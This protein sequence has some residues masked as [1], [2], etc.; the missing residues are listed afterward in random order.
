[1]K[2]KKFVPDFEDIPSPRHTTQQSPATEREDPFAEVDLGFVQEVAVAEARRCLACRRCIGC[3]L[4]L[5][6][7]DR[8]AIVYDEIPETVTLDI[9]AVILAPGGSEFDA[10]RARGLGYS[11]SLDVVSSMEFERIL[12]FSGPFGGLP[13]RPF[14][15][16][17]P[18]RIGFIQCVGSR[19]IYAGAPFCSTVC[20]QAMIRQVR[21][22][23]AKISSAE[24]VV[25]HRDIRPLGR[26]GERSLALLESDPRVRF[27]PVDSVEVCE[28]GASGH[29]D[30]RYK[31]RER[32][33]TDRFDLVVL[34]T[35][36]RGPRGAAELARR[37][38]IKV[39]RQGFAVRDGDAS[40]CSS[41]EGVFA[42]G[43]FAGPMGIGI[44]VSEG[45]GGA[46]AAA[47]AA[48]LT[49][50]GIEA[51]GPVDGGERSVESE[52]APAGSGGGEGIEVLICRQ[53]LERY[54]RKEIDDLADRCGALPAVSRVMVS[55]AACIGTERCEPE[56]QGAVPSRLVVVGCR[57]RSHYLLLSHVAC[58]LGIDPTRLSIVSS[59]DREERGPA[60]L[61]DEVEQVIK[62]TDREAGAEEQ[63]AERTPRVL[64]IGGGAAGCVASLEVASFG[65]EV[66]LVESGEN[67]GT[68]LDRLQAVGWE[69][70]DGD[71]IAG[72]AARVES[73]VLIHVHLSSRIAS[74]D[75]RDSGFTSTLI[76]GQGRETVLEHGAII[77]SGKGQEYRPALYRYGEDPLVATQV[78]FSR[79]LSQI[80]QT[81]GTVVMIQCVGSRCGERPYC[82]SICCDV[83]LRD[84]LRVRTLDPEGKVYI[85]HQGLRTYGFGEEQLYQ[86]EEAG[87]EFVR[88]AGMP[89]LV[90]SERLT[91]EVRDTGTDEP[92]RLEPD[93]LVLAAGVA[94]AAENRELAAAFGLDLDD[95]G[96]LTVPDPGLSPVDLPVKGMF[97]C[98]LAHEPLPLTHQIAEARAASGRACS[99][100]LASKRA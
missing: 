37:S 41:R 64:V 42:V 57:P 18:R 84:A 43:S 73:E 62:G 88:C 98:G 26:E 23:C 65:F 71:W 85:L 72:L 19:D 61:A 97:V 20:C 49:A 2:K 35:G 77:V 14:D 56:Q 91:I 60:D 15:G 95:D 4:C 40:L 86:A 3:G 76:D 46:L 9:G 33:E 12:S 99:L 100:L 30:V 1:M 66:D 63:G 51:G 17:I 53:G 75:R 45:I 13:M 38:G 67:L 59:G 78:E 93:V 8:R 27:I 55:A 16:Q 7:C 81:F 11:L 32:E 89:T 87:V 28:D 29:V 5:A 22:L 69:N 82:S 47:R 34:S 50:T 39:T 6:E 90:D 96:F 70:G 31:H 92:I 36:V 52:S 58:D 94:S 44:A 48:G 83:A 79:R 80:G 74:C 68:D 21:E 24:V 25:F 54:S 10:S